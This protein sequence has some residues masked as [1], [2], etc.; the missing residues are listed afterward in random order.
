[1]RGGLLTLI[2]LFVLVS[3]FIQNVLP[4]WIWP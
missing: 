4:H 3:I 1:V 2:L